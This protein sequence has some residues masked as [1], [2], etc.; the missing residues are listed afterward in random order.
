MTK[1]YS[2]KVINET[3][4]ITR[5]QFVS[6]CQASKFLRFDGSTKTRLRLFL[7]ATTIVSLGFMIL[8]T[9]NKA[10]AQE[11][12]EEAEIKKLI[13][14]DDPPVEHINII[15]SRLRQLEI[16]GAAAYISQEDLEKFEYGDINRILRS[17]P[18]VNLQEEDGY[19]LRPNIGI[20][21]T[22]LERSE[23]IT[24]MED[25][26]LIAPAPYAAPA[27]Y[28]FPTAARLSAIEILK[29]SS[30]IKFG[31]RTNGGVINMVSTPI[32]DDG[33]GFLTTRG[34]SDGFF[35]GHTSIGLTTGQISYNL[36]GLLSRGSGFK[37]L[38]SG[39]DTGFN[40]K[41]GVAKVRWTASEDAKYDQYIE[42]KLGLTEQLSNETYLGLTDADFAKNLY[43]R[44]AASQLDRFKSTHKQIQLTHLIEMSNNLDITTVAYY[45]TFERDW[46][47]L[48]D[49]NFDDGRGSIR[50][51]AVF[52][53]PAD[54]LNVAALA[55][56]RGESNSGD[57]ALQLRHNARQY[58]S[59]GFQSTAA[60]EF[61]VGEANH[62][63]EIGLRYHEDEEDRLQNREGF[64]MNS[65][66]MVQTS[67]GAEGSHA[68]RVA[69]AN[70]IAVF[71]QDEIVFGDWRIVPGLRFE[72]IN[73]QRDDF[74]KSDPSRAT[75]FTKRR[76]NKVDVFIP[77]LG[78]TYNVS[79][80]VTVLA[81]VHKG[82]SPPGPSS[83]NADAENSLNIELGMRYVSDYTQI[84]VI[85]FKNSYSNLLGT[86]TNAT[87]CV[88]GDVGDQYNGG[89]VGVSG[90]EF[91]A[92]HNLPV[93]NAMWVPIQISYTHTLAKFNTTFSDSFW[94]DVAV[95]DKLPYIPR[96][97]F[98]ISAGIASAYWEISANVNFVSST[99][100]GA[101]Q[102]SILADELIDSRLVVDL[103]A[104]YQVMDNIKLFVTADNAFA[105]KYVVARR[106]YGARPGK[107]RSVYL[108]LKLDF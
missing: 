61:A 6:S 60:Y 15:G 97:Q 50:P 64:A 30:S 58:Y 55:I 42:L 37:E 4:S 8:P 25:G 75:G 62:V 19:G 12:Q 3:K 83:N 10:I 45:N 5:L 7:Q 100:G 87:G 54:P 92:L 88:A 26:V 81:G 80:D 22:G 56:M 28:Y 33:V 39:A 78:V 16:P 79:N 99:R 108:G 82:F 77:G 40:I 73:L 59:A 105:A 13:T 38:P 51:S 36:E 41:D 96:N 63:M 71:V 2:K 85:G 46:F 86:C 44:Y 102:G 34:G 17:I 90:L 35:E 57:D 89:S 93:S 49:L 47:K 1:K 66:K 70:A 95:G 74:S 76:E 94:G 20:R 67:F 18:G 84:E 104:S 27:A 9:F 65:G 14:N 72:H 101:G 106:P 52:G 91:S 21:G 43:R 107:P 24:L 11:Q 32:S 23:H 98:N 69:S 29:G 68:N 53:N 48:D 103:S 31:P